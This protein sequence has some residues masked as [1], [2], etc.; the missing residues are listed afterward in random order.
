MGPAPELSEVEDAHT[1]AEALGALSDDVVSAIAACRK[2]RDS[3]L[4]ADCRWAIVR[5]LG[6]QDTEAA[7]DLCRELPKR[8][9]DEC[10]FILAETSLEP[11]WC[12]EAGYHRYSCRI[13]AFRAELSRWVP[14]DARPGEVEEEALRRMESLQLS[15]TDPGPWNFL[16]LHVLGAKRRVDVEVC[17]AVELTLARARCEAAALERS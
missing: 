15:P 10:F 6:A 16:Y 9:G 5:V 14:P 3:A 13:H 11:R 12:V 17:G 4:A 7:A 8:D 2:L 1:Y